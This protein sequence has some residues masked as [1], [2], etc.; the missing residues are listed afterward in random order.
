MG[1]VGLWQYSHTI[2]HKLITTRCSNAQPTSSDKK[3]GYLFI[4]IIFLLHRDPNT[5]THTTTH[6]ITPHTTPHHMTPHRTQHH[7]THDTH[8][9]HNTQHTTHNTQHDTT[10]NITQHTA[11]NTTQHTAHNITPHHTPP[12]PH[13]T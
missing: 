2:T 3:S 13:D 4:D 9:T 11:H 8:T 7:M 1:E 10:H 5:T 12:H 6:E